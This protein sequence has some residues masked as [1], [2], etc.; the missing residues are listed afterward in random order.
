MGLMALGA[1]CL[2]LFGL[3]FCA[4]LIIPGGL[5]QVP[6]STSVP[7]VGIIVGS[8]YLSC[9]VFVLITTFINII[10]KYWE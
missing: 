10:I 1:I 6:L 4:I 9:L 8:V 5:H 3:F 2:G 7:V